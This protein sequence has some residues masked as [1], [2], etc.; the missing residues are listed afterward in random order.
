M[1]EN[2]GRN[3]GSSTSSTLPYIKFS[4]SVICIHTMHYIPKHISIIII[5]SRKIKTTNKVWSQASLLNCCQKKCNAKTVRR[6]RPVW[7]Y[8]SNIHLQKK[9]VKHEF[10]DWMKASASQLISNKCIFIKKIYNSRTE[11][12]PWP[13]YRQFL[14]CE[15][16]PHG[17]WPASVLFKKKSFIFKIL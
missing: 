3:K 12:R 2:T 13:V 10:Q 5:H 11:C 4:I 9:Y 7:Q 6:P 14:C 16:K 15:G 8:I 1:W 17:L